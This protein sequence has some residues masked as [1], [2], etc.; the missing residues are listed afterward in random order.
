MKQ[1]SGNIH[2]IVDEG[3]MLIQILIKCFFPFWDA[4]EISIW[5]SLAIIK[6]H[7]RGLHNWSILICNR[8]IVNMY[9]V[10]Q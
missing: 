3:S 9:T 4:T 2:I 5:L 8:T 10:I 1:T 6:S 7:S